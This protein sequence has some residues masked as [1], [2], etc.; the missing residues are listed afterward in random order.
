MTLY[1][2]S[3]FH[4]FTI[5][6]CT[7]GLIACSSKQIKWREEV[8]LQGDEIVLIE[9]TAK[10][11]SF[12]EIGGSG[13]WE[14]EEMSIKIIRS[15]MN[16][17][18]PTWTSKLIPI[19]LD[20]NPIDSRWVIVATISTCTDWEELGRPKL[21]YKEYEVRN[22]EWHPHDISQGLVGRNT[23]LLTSI[24]LAGE[25][26][27]TVNEKE[28]LRKSVSVAPKFKKILSTWTSNC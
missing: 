27:Y 15:G 10:G 18:P 19:I 12:G 3:A 5:L 23:N 26:N 17:N 6:L 14:S 2:A 1:L 16:D 11:K 24:H 28:L 25:K 8:K 20:R 7:L 9:R 22:G 13:G 21:P 4:K